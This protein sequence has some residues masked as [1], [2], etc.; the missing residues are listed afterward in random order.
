VG[1]ELNIVGFRFLDVKERGKDYLAEGDLYA[2][3]PDLS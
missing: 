1:E 3:S 2:A